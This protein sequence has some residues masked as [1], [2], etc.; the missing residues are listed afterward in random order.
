MSAEL[1][2]LTFFQDPDVDR[3]AALVFDL[4]AQLHIERQRRM[5]LETAL[6]KSGTVE[7][8]AL[9]ALADDEAFLAQSRAALDAAQAR[10]F[11]IL[12]ERGDRRAPL[13]AQSRS[14]PASGAGR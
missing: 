2:E 10:L 7:E 5:A 6:V 14:V 9:V 1:Q 8:S 13:R 3:L 11:T 12:E 4:A